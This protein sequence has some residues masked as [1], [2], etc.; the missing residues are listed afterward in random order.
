MELALDDRRVERPADVLGDD[1]VEDADLA[2]VAVDADV[3]QMG[4]GQRRE[5]RRDRAGVALERLEVR[6]KPVEPLPDLGQRQI[7]RSGVPFGR[8]TPSTSSRSRTSI[9]SA[10]AA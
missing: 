10:S 3:D 8:T 5:A 6:R 1:V 9:S 7:P 2:A 4:D